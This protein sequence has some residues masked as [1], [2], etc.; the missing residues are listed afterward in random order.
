MWLDFEKVLD[1]DITYGEMMLL[2]KDDAETNHPQHRLQLRSLLI[3][4][5]N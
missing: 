3:G 2:H 1:L 4:Y 5:L